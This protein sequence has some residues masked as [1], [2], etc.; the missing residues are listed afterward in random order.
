MFGYMPFR[1][2]KSVTLDELSTTTC[3]N[4]FHLDHNVKKKE[5]KDKKNKEKKKEKKNQ[6]YKRVYYETSSDVEMAHLFST[7]SGKNK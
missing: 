2:D 3:Y 4:P 7:P 6:M 1:A 5:K